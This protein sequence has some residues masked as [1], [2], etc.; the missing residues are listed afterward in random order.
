MGRTLRLFTI[1][2]IPIEVHA[3]WLAIYAL[4]AWTLA[5]GYFPRALP[6][7]GR[8]SAWAFG[9]IC[10][11]L[12]FASVLVHELAHS[13]VA[14]GYGL[15]V[16][17]I[18]LHIFGGVSHLED[19]PPSP[20]AEALIAAAGP[21]AS[22]VIAG[23]LWAIRKTTLA[24]ET[25]ASAIVSYLLTVNAM[26][27]VFNLLPGFPLDGGRLLRAALWRWHGSLARATYL[28]S[29]VGVAAAYALIV[30]GVVQTFGGGS[31]GGM[32]LVLIGIFLH[33]AA[34]TSW[35][36]MGLRETLG[37]LPVAH[38]MTRTV[39]TVGPDET[40]SAL[41]D[42]LWEHHVASFPVVD[43]GRV[44]GIAGTA[45]LRRFPRERWPFT[46]VRDVMRPLDASLR[47]APDESVYRAL[48]RA[49]GNGI[50]RLAVMDGDRLAGYVSMQD[51]THV[52]TLEE[53][54]RQ[55]PPL[56]RAA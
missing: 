46:R 20:R 6:E 4:I 51:I 56:R 39:V 41:V 19:E 32:W 23:V 16:R 5:V 48:E 25:S 38:I 49:S 33:H 36:Q 22:F 24:P 31:I 21:L 1:A 14:T 50:G 28:A 26:V 12:L 11:L 15:T 42:R 8:G 44:L 47:I 29:R 10:A 3:S 34:N 43:G 13:I 27:G 30:W 40:V 37:R 2:R 55:A 52:L 9:L 35:T 45:A 18:T 53:L 54:G 7:I 17:G